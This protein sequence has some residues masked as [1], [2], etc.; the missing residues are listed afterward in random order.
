[1]LCP[2]GNE[3]D[4]APMSQFTIKNEPDDVEQFGVKQ[5][6]GQGDINIINSPNHMPFW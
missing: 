5:E 6:Q 2:K 3:N 4:A 1:M